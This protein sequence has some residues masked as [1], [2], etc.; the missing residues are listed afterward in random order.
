MLQQVW[1]DPF[2]MDLTW[3]RLLDSTLAYVIL[4]SLYYNS[5]L[6][7]TQKHGG[8]F[9]MDRMPKKS[10]DLRKLSFGRVGFEHRGC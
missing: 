6:L 4:L 3:F 7:F 10:Q 9:L 2:Q 8:E 5:L 1:K